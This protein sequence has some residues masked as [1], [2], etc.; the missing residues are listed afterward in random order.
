MKIRT[1]ARRDYILATATRA[2][3]ELGYERTSMSDISARVGGSK[4]TLYGYFPSKEELFLATTHSL[5]DKY[6]GPALAELAT[7][8]TDEPEQVL[9]RLGEVTLA[10]ICSPDA[11]ATYRMVLA[12]AGHTDVGKRFHETGIRQSE[13]TIASYLRELMARGRLRDSDPRIAAKHFFGLLTAET[14]HVLFYR[15]RP[16]L[17]RKQIAAYVQRAVAVFMGGYGAR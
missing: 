8:S 10:F 1:D 15:D 3:L 4:A 13:E 2:F 5:A 17:T 12:E 9:R 6:I 14:Q 11:L 16:K 7:S